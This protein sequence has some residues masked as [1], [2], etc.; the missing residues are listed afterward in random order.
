MLKI[1]VRTVRLKLVCAGSFTGPKQSVSLKDRCKQILVRMQP[2]LLI[3]F[4]LPAA[5]EYIVWTVY[6]R[7]ILLFRCDRFNSFLNGD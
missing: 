6:N 5:T 2:H 4:V 7:M 3:L 1:M